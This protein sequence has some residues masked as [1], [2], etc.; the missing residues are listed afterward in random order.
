MIATKTTTLMMA[1]A[2]IGI[3]SPAAAHAQT[4]DLLELVEQ[5][6]TPAQTVD[7]L[8]LVEQSGTAGQV[9]AP[10]QEQGAA[11]V[12]EED[13]NTPTN[14][15]FAT[16]APGGT[17][18]APITTIIEDADVL[19]NEQTETQDAEAAQVPTQT[20][21]PTQIPTLTNGDLAGLLPAA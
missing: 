9:S 19:A 4:V 8:E 13:H 18:F 11:N 20:Q 15:I 21:T 12:D 2:V 16:V 5:S 6:G 7:L 10:N 17:L 1:M 14:I 3:V